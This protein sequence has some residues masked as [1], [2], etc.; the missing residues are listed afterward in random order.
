MCRSIMIKGLDAL[1]IESYTTARHHGVEDAMVAT[2]Q[3]TFPGIGWTEQGSYFFSRVAQHAKRGAE[4]MREVANTVRE[5]GVEPFMAAA[6]AEKHDWMAEQA[7]QG[8]FQDGQPGN[9]NGSSSPTLCS[10]R[11]AK[12]DHTTTD[13]TAAIQSEVPTKPPRRPGARRGYRALDRIKPHNRCAAASTAAHR[14]R[15]GEPCRSG[16]E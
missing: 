11:A 13:F 12:A 8:V 10:M 2:L 15:S 14:P 1:V 9:P 7:R 4:E 5:A 3:E 16:L 6:I